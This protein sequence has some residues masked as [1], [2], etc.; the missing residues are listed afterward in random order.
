MGYD[1][2]MHL[3]KMARYLVSGG[4][5]TLTNLCVLFLLVHF[6]GMHYLAA[7]VIAFCAGII[8]SFTLHK[9]WTFGNSELSRVHFQLALYLVVAAGNVAANS[10]LV[11]IFVEWLALWY[12]LAQLL[13]SALIAVNSYFIYQA[14]VFN[15]REE[16]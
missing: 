3:P 6:L 14:F 4:S 8:V 7:S 1:A 11:Y 16:A 9:F 12:L 5:A 15:A 13:A 2:L 10:V